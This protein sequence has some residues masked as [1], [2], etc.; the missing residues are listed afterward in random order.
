MSTTEIDVDL[1]AEVARLRADLATAQKR[2]EWAQRENQR[3]ASELT[4]RFIRAGRPS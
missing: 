3:L 1:I 4:R 2:L